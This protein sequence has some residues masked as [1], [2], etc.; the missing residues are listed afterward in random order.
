MELYKWDLLGW[1]WLLFLEHEGLASWLG[2]FFPL[3]QSF[4]LP[5]SLGRDQGDPFADGGGSWKTGPLNLPCIPAS[6]LSQVRV[7]SVCHCC[8]TA[9]CVITIFIIFICVH[10][11]SWNSNTQRYFSCYVTCFK[12]TKQTWSPVLLLAGLLHRYWAFSNL[13]PFVFNGYLALFC[14]RASF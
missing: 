2:C 9:I 5:H 14:G 12:K 10:V 3:P 4:L 8:A 13:F 7:A 11:C 6:K 1:G